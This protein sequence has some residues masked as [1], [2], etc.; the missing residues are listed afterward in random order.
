MSNF[1]DN[2]FGNTLREIRKSKGLSQENM[3]DMLN[4]TRS[5]YGKYETGDCSPSLQMIKEI[6]N[7]FNISSDYL[8]GIK[9]DTIINKENTLRNPFNTTELYMYFNAYSKKDESFGLGEYKLVF[10]NFDDK[11]FVDFCDMNNKIYERGY[12]HSDQCIAVLVMENYKLNNPRLEVSEI[13]INISEGKQETYFGTYL[14]TNGEYIPSIRKCLFSTKPIKNK[15][16]IIDTLRVSES[17]KT[18]L[19]ETYALYLNIFNLEYSG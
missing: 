2:E 18:K 3:A 7:I 13:I 12:I 1:C 19:N 14:G 4:I 16:K 17:E 6:C 15:S 9:N 10:H 8:L 5:A 11:C